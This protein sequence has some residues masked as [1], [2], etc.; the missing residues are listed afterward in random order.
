MSGLPGLVVRVSDAEPAL[1][2][3]YQGT[4]RVARILAGRDVQE[5]VPLLGRVFA[6]CPAAQQLAAMLALSA[7]AGQPVDADE[8]AALRDAAMA[9]TVREHALRVF[10]GWTAALGEAPDRDAAM[11]VN[12]ATRSGGAD[13]ALAL[14]EERVFGC[15][16]D[17]W[18]A[19]ESLPQWAARG[20]TVAARHMLRALGQDHL[21]QADGPLLETLVHRHSAAPALADVRSGSVASFHAARL[22]DLAAVVKA[23]RSGDTRTPAVAQRPADGGAQ[24]TV[25]CAR[26]ALTHRARAEHGRV[27]DYAILSPTD[28]ALAQGGFVRPWLAGLATLPAGDRADAAREIVAAVDPCTHWRVEAGRVEAGR[29]EVG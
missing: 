12:R 26:G 9:E 7:A 10:L 15:P 18:L 2:V 22:A 23:M 11:E 13:R 5:V 3:D 27:S 8:H 20:Q 19:R 24:V 28:T 1:T 6:I 17:E 16:A 4:G 14:I 25:E 21:P 29:E